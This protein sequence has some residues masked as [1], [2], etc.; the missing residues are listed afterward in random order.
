MSVLLLT[1]LFQS[2]LLLPPRTALENP[3][4]VSPVPQKLLKDYEKMWVRFVG[5]KE[6]SKLM[7]DLDKLLEKEKTFDPAWMIEGY[8]ALYKG[9]DPV[10]RDRFAQALNV[11][12]NNRI[13]MYYLAELA[14][15]KADYARAS[16]LY[17]QLSSLGAN[18]PELE[19]KRQKAFLLA[20]D[21][22]LRSAARA[23]SENRLGE[24]EDYYRQALTIA[25]NEPVL[26]AR[27]ADLLTR[28]DKKEEAAAERK[29][30]DDLIPR[31]VAETGGTDRVKADNLEDLGR[32]GGDIGLFHQIREAQTVTREQFAVLIVRYFPQVTELRQTPQI[33]TD[34]QNSGARS[35]IQTVIGLGL[36]EPF[37][38]H[39]FVPSAFITRGDF[40]RALARLSRLIGLPA[41]SAAL[42]A[43]SDVGP[44]NAMYPDIQLVLG[45][46]LMTL[47][48][49]GS[50]DV[51][52]YVTGSQAVSSAD[53]LLR[54]FQQ[55]QR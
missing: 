7:K 49:S 20:T 24:A 23:E 36:V 2:S 18:T 1:L 46:G 3:A 47:Q 29:A 6:D 30:A 52:G 14:Y 19:T 38:N 16:M 43:A 10:A 51:S 13:A 9:A 32:W 15:T 33:V 28:Q 55:V 53:R 45:S 27:L 17:A 41:N 31:R 25:P 5:A 11:N 8:I 34:I 54:T 12:R 44:T 21:G 22:L 37:P 40:A 42:A 35:E 4:T 39:D 50:F 48:D 26:H